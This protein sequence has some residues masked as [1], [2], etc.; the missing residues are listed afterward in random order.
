MDN[1][2]AKRVFDFGWYQVFRAGQDEDIYLVV[3][4]VNLVAWNPL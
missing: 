3:E 2:V 1:A 4:I